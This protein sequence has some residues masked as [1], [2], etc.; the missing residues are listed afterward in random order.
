MSFSL[1][2]GINDNEWLSH[3]DLEVAQSGLDSLAAL[4]LL[5]R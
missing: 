1:P 5:S 3:E 4:P 2:Y